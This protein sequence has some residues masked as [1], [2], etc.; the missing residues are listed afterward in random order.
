MPII[1]SR[2]GKNAQKVH[3]SGVV[4][5]GYLQ[6]YVTSNPDALP[7]T[8][9]KEDVRLMIVGREFPTNSGPV[10]VLAVDGDGDIYLIETK[11]YKNPDKRLVLAQVLD[12]GAALWRGYGDPSNFIADVDRFMTRRTGEGLGHNLN[13]FFGY[14]ELQI[15]EVMDAIRNQIHVG[16]FRFVIL[17]DQLTERLR[18]LI[19]YMNERTAFDIYAVEMEFYQHQGLEIV[20]PKLFGA[21]VTKSVTS[22]G[23]GIQSRRWDEESFFAALGER[24]PQ[25]S[26]EVAKGIMA[27]TK[28]NADHV[29]WGHGSRD[30]SFGDNHQVAG[31]KYN[32]FA[33]YTYGKIEI[34]FQHLANKPSFQSEAKRLELRDRLNE[35]AGVEI[36]AEALVKRP[37]IPL[38]VLVP[39]ESQSAFQSVLDWILN[40]TRSY[41]AK[42]N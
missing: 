10:D 18:D 1:V 32:F 31:V 3:E 41:H 19:L 16:K 35:I 2:R 33:V 5:E 17:M 9:I 24:S 34:Y 7:I 12:Y 14:D 36:P 11:L 22:G 40:E 23:R 20:I 29:W 15:Q 25:S 6:E 30:G 27:W 26:V 39:P 8:D 13:S 38:A 42:A 4:N 37:S 28:R 21:Q